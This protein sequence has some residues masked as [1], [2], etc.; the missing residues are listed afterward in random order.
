MKIIN[1]GIINKIS[2]Y[3]HADY[4]SANGDP[5]VEAFLN[6]FILLGVLILFLGLFVITPIIV[7]KFLKRGN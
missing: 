5:G 7:N 1:Q 2:P 3:L 6:L 4:V